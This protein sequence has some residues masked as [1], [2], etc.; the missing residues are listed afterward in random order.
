MAIKILYPKKFET[1]AIAA[2]VAEILTI[3]VGIEEVVIS[4]TNE[5]IAIDEI[6]AG[7]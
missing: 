3:A 5:S 6:A 1:D 7:P 4:V 2:E